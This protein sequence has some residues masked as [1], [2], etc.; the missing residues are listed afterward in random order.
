MKHWIGALLAVV[1]LGTLAGCQTLKDIDDAAG[2]LARAMKENSSGRPASRQQVLTMHEARCDRVDDSVTLAA[3]NP[4]TAYLRLKRYF[5]YQTWEEAEKRTERGWLEA[6]NFRHETL[7]G[8]RYAMAQDVFWPSHQLG[9]QHVWLMMDIERASRG[10][11]VAWSYC[12]GT[13]GYEK[14]NPDEVRRYLR[15]DIGEAASGG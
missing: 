7:P 13:D 9:R 6:S 12:L 10:A 8:V 5:G 1:L 14:L 4:D 3:V 11:T 2:E 15:R